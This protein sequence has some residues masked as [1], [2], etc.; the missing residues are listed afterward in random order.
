MQLSSQT[1][2]IEAIG[3]VDSGATINVLPFDIEVSLGAV[4]EEQKAIIPSAGNLR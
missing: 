1:N 4:W 3:L 2:T